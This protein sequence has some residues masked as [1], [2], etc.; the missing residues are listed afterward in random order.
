MLHS[1]PKEEVKDLTTALRRRAA[2]LFVTSLTANFY[3]SFHSSSWSKFV[4]AMAVA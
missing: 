4:A 2:Y 1:V 3:E